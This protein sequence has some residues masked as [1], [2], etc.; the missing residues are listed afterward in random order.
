MT[1]IFYTFA[2][3]I[4]NVSYGNMYEIYYKSNY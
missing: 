1:D 2:V 4:L 3:F